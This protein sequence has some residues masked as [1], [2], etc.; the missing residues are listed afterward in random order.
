[1]RSRNQS[2]I[3]VISAAADVVLIFCAYMLAV[4]LRFD[5]LDGVVSISM[6]SAGFQA[7]IWGYALVV[8]LLYAG[9][10]L[11]QPFRRVRFGRDTGIVLLVNT[12]C[13]MAL[14]SLL[15][16]FRLMD[17]SRVTLILFWLISSALVVLRMYLAEKI[18]RAM[19]KQDKYLRHVIVVGNG[20]NARNYIKAVEKQ[21]ELGIKVEGYISGVP[22]EG[23]G[24]N[25]GS[26]EEIGAI[27]EAGVYDELVVALEPHEI[28]F[29]PL[30]LMAAEK[31]YRSCTKA[32]S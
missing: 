23:L 15:F 7:G 18:R 11:Y 1:M 29:M 22:K 5:V 2:I 12:V 3:G 9:G 17:A 20:K 13:V 27:L 8:V 28:D 24:K 25:L 21:P 16:T 14:M 19:R 30:M 31:E 32:R 6:D 4:T 10:H 26:Y